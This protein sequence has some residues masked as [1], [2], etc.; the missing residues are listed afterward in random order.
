[1]AEEF[2]ARVTRSCAHNR[3]DANVLIERMYR[4][5]YTMA[6]DRGYAIASRCADLQAIFECITTS[7]PV[8]HGTDGARELRMFVIGED[9]V[10][11]KTARALMQ[12]FPDGA[13]V[14]VSIEGPTA[15][16]RKE[17]DAAGRVLQRVQF[18]SIAEL[19]NNVSQH[20]LQPAFRRLATAETVAILDKFSTTKAQ[21][22]K[23]RWQDPIRRYYDYA[24]E[25]LIEIKRR[26]AAAG[27]CLPHASPAPPDPPAFGVAGG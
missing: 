25:D 11:I 17:V 21:L 8:L 18:F 3:V 13:L 5:M 24:K 2:L 15:F 23:L 4:N 20:A 16:T 14:L 27:S 19:L 9:K 7:T 22:P 6:R 12:S 10:G 26:R 1:M